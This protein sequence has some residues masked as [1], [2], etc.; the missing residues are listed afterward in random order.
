MA[1]IF[2]KAGR[3]RAILK[4]H[5][6]IFSRA[7]N[8]VSGTPELGETVNVI[9]SQGGFLAKAAYN[10]NSNILGRIWT[11]DE[12]EQVDTDFFTRRITKSLQRRYDLMDLIH[13]DAYRLIYAESDGLP[14]LILDQY[15]D[16]FVIQLLT[17]GVEYWKDV[18]IEIIIQA[19]RANVLFE[20]SDQDVRAL[21]GLP[22]VKGVL[23]GKIPEGEVMIN[24]N[25]L[26]FSIDIINGH[27]TGFYLDQREN[28]NYAK[29]LSKG[30]KVLDCFSY[31]GG[32]TIN[33]LIGGAESVTLVDSSLNSLEHAQKNIQLNNQNLESEYY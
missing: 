6:W 1:D 23:Y 14:G 29:F 31:T 15:N 7:V 10:P 13:S 28:R 2:L 12:N 25:D 33:C 24:E 30:K 8:R 17:A 22:S 16:V 27:K 32:F 26:I 20:R 4:H 5:P 9:S 19:T 21:E 11:W 3:E 18:L